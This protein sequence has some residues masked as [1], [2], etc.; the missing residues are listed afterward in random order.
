MRVYRAIESTL[1]PLLAYGFTF[2]R[3]D[4][5]IGITLDGTMRFVMARELIGA[6]DPCGYIAEVFGL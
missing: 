6:D 3:Q 1:A 5:H 2:V 4:D